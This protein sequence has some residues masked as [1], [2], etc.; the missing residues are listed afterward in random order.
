[1]SHLQDTNCISLSWELKGSVSLSFSLCFVLTIISAVQFNVPL[2]PLS[3]QGLIKKN[4]KQWLFTTTK[5]FKR[6]ALP[7]SC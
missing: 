7:K 6:F 3:N 5:N 2:A 4:E 1:M